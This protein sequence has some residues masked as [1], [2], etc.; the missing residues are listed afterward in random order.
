MKN[1]NDS[2][3]C[4]LENLINHHWKNLRLGGRKLRT[5]SSVIYLVRLKY[6]SSITAKTS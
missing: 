3:F 1:V 4:H 5:V 2:V 6:L